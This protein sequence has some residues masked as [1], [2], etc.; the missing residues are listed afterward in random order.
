MTKINKDNINIFL[1]K[2]ELSDDEFQDIYYLIKHENTDSILSKLGKDLIRKYLNT[3]IKSDHIF[4]FSCK[5]E[6]QIIGYILLAKRS[7]YLINEFMDLR[8]KIIFGLLKK[9]KF[10]LLLNILISFFKLDLLLIEKK[11]KKIIK[12]SLNLNLLAIKKEYQS[13]GIGKLFSQNVLKK[14]YQNHFKF[15]FI[16]VEAPNSNSINFYVNKLNFKPIGRKIRFFK[17]FLVLLKDKV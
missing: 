4:L 8:F 16:S 1:H 5:I 17:F 13:Q 7:E 15:D 11:N 2:K 6:E 10:I 14:I 3:A 12:E 9:V